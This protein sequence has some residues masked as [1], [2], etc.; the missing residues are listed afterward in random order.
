MRFEDTP[1]LFGCGVGTGTCGDIKCGICRTTYNEGEDERAVYNNDSISFTNF[2]GLTI[3]DCC[4]EQ[5]EN[6]V[7]HRMP[8]I[9]SWY[10]RI[11]DA[12]K[13]KIEKAD[14]QLQTIE[15]AK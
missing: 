1:D 10:R 7:F 9:L 11:L 5:I 6:A 8:D 4:F 2:A 13:Q 3:C 12:Q 14:A 15:G